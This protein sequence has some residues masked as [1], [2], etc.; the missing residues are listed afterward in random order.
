MSL[1]ALAGFAVVAAL[2]LVMVPIGAVLVGVELFGHRC[3]ELPSG[4]HLEPHRALS[5]GRVIEASHR[6]VDGELE[7]SRRALPSGR[8]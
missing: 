3:P 4:R 2:L 1:L 5:G 8:Y 6:R 7:Q